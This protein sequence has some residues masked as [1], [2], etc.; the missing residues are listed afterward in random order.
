MSNYNLRIL[1]KQLEQQL[2]QTEFDNL[3]FEL[4]VPDSVDEIE[5]RSQ[6]A[7]AVINYFRHRNDGLKIL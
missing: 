1:R 4:D 3:L 6:K 7:K 5:N 2:N